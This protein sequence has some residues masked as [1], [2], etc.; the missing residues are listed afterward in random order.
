[1]PL[2]IYVSAK[3]SSEVYLNGRFVG[4]NGLPAATAAQEIPGVMDAVINAP[5]H[6]FRTGRNEVTLRMSSHH[7]FVRLGQPV[8]WIAVGAA[9]QPQDGFLRHYWP[10]LITFGAFI[11]GALY[12]WVAA[13]RGED[14]RGSLMLALI[15]LLAAGQ[16]FTEVS[17][18]IFAYPYPL[19]DLRLILIVLFSAGFGLSVAFHVAR[20]LNALHL[21]WMLAAGCATAIAAVAA[22]G[23][24]LKAAAA[25][26]TPLAGCA[27]VAGRCAIQRRPGALQSVIALGGFIALIVSFPVSFLDTLFFHAIAVLLL[28][29]FV[30]QALTLARE[31]QRSRQQQARADQLELA[32]EQA[33]QNDEPST[34]TVR[35]AGKLDIIRADQITHCQGAGGYAEL[36]LVEGRKL[37][38]TATL[39]ELAESL[40]L[41]FL[42]V[43]RSYLVNTTHVRALRRNASGPGRLLL[44]DGTEV[45]VSRRVMPKI[46]LAIDSGAAVDGRDASRSLPATAHSRSSPE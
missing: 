46:R 41:T 10:S 33:R 18:G 19:H 36:H 35:S 37:L 30:Q 24:D 1:M 2:A 14:R 40:P 6:L 3:A 27:V 26:L 15:S 29:L 31:A 4:R 34:I 8:H 43:H 39:N 22:T 12:F 7:G 32:L 16:L 42:R 38:H 21:G 28:F 20:K 44:S 9:G 45:P 17:R 25:M 5:Q 13:L 23:Y 11:M